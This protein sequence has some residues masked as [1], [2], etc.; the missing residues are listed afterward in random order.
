MFILGLVRVLLG[1]YW[2]NGKEYGS[3]YR[4]EALG[5]QCMQVTCARV[6]S[7]LWI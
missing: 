1:L 2:D 6:G 3:Y 7:L 4:V 5:M